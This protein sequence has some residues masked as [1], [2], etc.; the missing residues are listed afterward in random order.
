MKTLILDSMIHPQK[1]TSNPPTPIV[2]HYPSILPT[3]VVHLV[4]SP[5]K[6]YLPVPY[7]GITRTTRSME[8]E[9]TITHQTWTTNIDLG[10]VLLQRVLPVTAS[11]FPNAV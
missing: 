8:L 7:D 11:P 2:H 1:K 3:D 5:T 9:I 10:L 6:I 4:I